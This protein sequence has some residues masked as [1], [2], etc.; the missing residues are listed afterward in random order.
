MKFIC[1][2]LW[3]Y[4]LWLYG[5]S[6]PLLETSKCVLDINRTYSET[7]RHS[8]FKHRSIPTTF[9]TLKMLAPRRQTE[10]PDHYT[11]NPVGLFLWHDDTS[12]NWCGFNNTVSA[13][14]VKA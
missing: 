9:P 7:H 8:V 10:V 3:L 13:T 5:L 4:G 12:I 2:G 14:M 11:N 1:Y 6:D